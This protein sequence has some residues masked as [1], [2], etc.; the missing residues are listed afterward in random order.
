MDDTLVIHHDQ[1]LPGVSIADM[2]HAPGPSHA[3]KA[4]AARPHDR[5]AAWLVLAFAGTTMVAFNMWHAIHGGIP[6]LLAIL[7]GLAPV[8]LAMGLSH[9]VAAYRGGWFMKGVTFAIMVGAM[10]LSIRATG[11][12]VKPASG[13]MWPL[14]GIVT[15]SAALLALQVILSPESRAAAKA[16][17]KDASKAMDEAGEAT[18]AADGTPAKSATDALDD[19]PVGWILPGIV[20]TDSGSANG[21][22]ALYR[23]FDVDS[24]L[25]YVGVTKDFG[26]RWK[27]HMGSK[28]WFGEIHRMSVVWYA[29]AKAALEA[30]EEAIKDE[31]PRH[32][33][34]HNPNPVVRPRRRPPARA[35]EPEAD[36]ARAAYRKSLRDGQPLSDRALGAMYGRSRTWGGNRI[37]EVEAG[38]RPV[39]AAGSGN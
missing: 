17:R 2:A 15:D 1:P 21:G 36:K 8:V 28:G 4:M 13:G 24:D 39:A 6:Y 33:V 7:Y 26:Q 31:M 30:E 37:K 10:A 22:T 18:Q 27:D 25:L 14:F 34:T 23:F 11:Y 16:A 38:P 3:R 35:Q 9:M 32:N 20:Y 19:G 29:D 12:V 5:I